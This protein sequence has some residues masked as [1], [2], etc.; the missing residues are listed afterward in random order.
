MQVAAGSVLNTWEIS[1]IK[2]GEN[3]ILKRGRI[4]WMSFLGCWYVRACVCVCMCVYICLC[5][6]CVCVLYVH[7][8]EKVKVPMKAWRPTR[9][10]AVL[11]YPAPSY[12]GTGIL[13]ECGS[14]QGAGRLQRPSLFPAALELQVLWLH[15]ALH[16]WDLSSDLDT[17]TESVL[18]HWAV[19]SNP[20]DLFVSLFI[21]FKK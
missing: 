17:Y 15:K 1:T 11:L 3:V 7:I 20:W 16:C 10:S 8:W 21:N 13:T 14:K 5:M 19:F 6:I 2:A 18:I 9:T 12:L 4:C